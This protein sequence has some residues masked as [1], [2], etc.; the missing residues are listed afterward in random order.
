MSYDDEN[1]YILMEVHDAEH[2]FFNNSN[3][4]WRGDSVQFAICSIGKSYEHELSFVCDT[5][6]NTSGVY[7]ST[8]SG[9]E[10]NRVSLAT[11]RADGV[12][13]YEAAIPWDMLF[14]QIPEKC[15]MSFAVNDLSL[16]HIYIMEE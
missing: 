11:S 15:L 8:F 10:P 4:Y 6:N 1:F 9:S 12:T 16:I 2:V 3:D 13:T 5:D 7:S 14:E